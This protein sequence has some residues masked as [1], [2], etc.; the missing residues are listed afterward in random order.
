MFVSR[1]STLFDSILSPTKESLSLVQTKLT[2][3]ST[4]L[5]NL[6]GFPSFNLS[7]RTQYENDVLVIPCEFIDERYTKFSPTNAPSRNPPLVSLHTVIVVICVDIQILD[8][9]KEEIVLITDYSKLLMSRCDLLLLVRELPGLSMYSL[10]PYFRSFLYLCF[11]A[12]YPMQK[13]QLDLLSRSEHIDL[14][15]LRAKAFG[16]LLD[17]LSSV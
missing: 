2:Q 15:L 6:V 11:I 4:T 3:F 16:P 13:D 1:L 17:S 10:I 12:T 5:I 8:D 14:S 9:L 7:Q